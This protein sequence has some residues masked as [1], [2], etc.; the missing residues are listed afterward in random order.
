[1][2]VASYALQDIPSPAKICLC[3]ILMNLRLSPALMDPTGNGG[4]A[5]DTLLADGFEPGA[6]GAA[7]RIVSR[8]IVCY[9]ER[10]LTLRNAE[11]TCLRKLVQLRFVG[12]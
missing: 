11:A 9:S 6:G 7:G 10:M 3:T 12:A 2:V 4:L 8:R 5:C 1:M